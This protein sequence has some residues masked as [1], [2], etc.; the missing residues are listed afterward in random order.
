M[1]ELTTTETKPW[2]A[3]KG[4]LGPI[5]AGLALVA[6]LFGVTI[7]PATQAVIVDQGVA[8]LTA[9]VTFGG[10]VVGIWGRISAVRKIG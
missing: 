5:V 10:L 3:S 7:D 8:L 6:S 2:Y 4:V 1:T 9:A